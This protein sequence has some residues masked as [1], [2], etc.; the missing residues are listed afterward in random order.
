[1]SKETFGTINFSSKERRTKQ[2][3]AA[4]YIFK[5]GHLKKADGSRNLNS[6]EQQMLE[7]C[8]CMIKKEGVVWVSYDFLQQKFGRCRNTIK[9]VLNAISGHI[10]WRFERSVRI[11]GH[12]ELNVIIIE[13]IG[14]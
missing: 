8:L 3:D 4:K 13:R 14:K 9:R 11:N 1:M 7:F 2:P 6:I 5:Y 10:S 12:R